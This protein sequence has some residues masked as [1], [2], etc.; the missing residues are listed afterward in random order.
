ML[1]ARQITLQRG[2]TRILDGADLVLR[3]GEFLAVLGPNGAGKTSLLRILTGEYE[4]DE[5]A[6]LLEGSPLAA[7]SLA[8]L[9]R[10]RAVLA[11]SYDLSFPFKVIEVVTM[12]RAP[13]YGMLERPEDWAIARQAL[14][15][16]EMSAF[17]DRPYPSLSGGEKQ[18]VQLARILAQ[19]WRT[20]GEAGDP[21][22][23][24]RY[25]FLDEPTS[26]LDLAHQ[27]STL[28]LARDLAHQGVA[29]LA[30]LHDLNQAAVYA[31]RVVVMDHGKVALEGSTAEIMAHPR[32]EEVFQVRLEAIIS[33]A[34]GRPHIFVTPRKVLNARD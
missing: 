8:D 21:G 13:W 3:P 29:V 16:V 31:D 26:S 4:P 15:L 9:S 17:A 28:A 23:K 32:L 19:I 2:K 12:G 5:G 6:V 20:P 14:E 11:Q 27:H 7:A 1:E 34:T 24:A 33:P 25:L 30:I 18:R 22:Q 10:R